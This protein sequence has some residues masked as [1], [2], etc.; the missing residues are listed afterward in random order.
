MVKEDKQP[1]RAHPCPHCLA[2]FQSPSQRDTH[3]RAVH[4]KWRDYAYAYFSGEP[5]TAG[6][7]S[8]HAS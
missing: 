4:E 6:T 8:H 1:K 2:K 7:I 5:F 3:A